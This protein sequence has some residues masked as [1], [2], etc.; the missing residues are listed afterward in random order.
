MKLLIGSHNV[1]KI[2]ELK[3]YLGH[4][5]LD[6]VG[7]ID[8]NFQDDA[9][10]EGETF[11]DVALGKAK[12]YAERTEYAVLADD[13]GFEVDALDGQPGVHSKRWVGPSGTDE[14][15]IQKI[16]RL[17]E[18]IPPSERT[19][20]LKLV[21]V[22]YFPSEREYI[23]AERSIEGIVPDKPAGLRIP[24]FPY[25]SALFL[26]QFNKYYGELTEEEHNQINHRK[27]AC[28]ELLLK[29]EPWINN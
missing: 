15:R 18:G 26:P 12:W 25:R 22:V 8:V 11:F 23:S 24:G 13:G 1:A 19:A 17:L 28:K 29:L 9:P 27:D 5:K 4:S 6:V 16:F 20:R 3:K 2:P 14:D 21:L 7:L 10:E